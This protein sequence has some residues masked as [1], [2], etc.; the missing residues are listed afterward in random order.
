MKINLLRFIQITFLLSLMLIPDSGFAQQDKA[1]NKNVNLMGKNNSGLPASALIVYIDEDF[2]GAVGTTPPTGW[3]QNIIIGEQ[4]VDLW[5]FD[6]PGGVSINFPMT[7]PTAIFDSYHL[8]NNNLSENV[9]LESP[10]FSIEEGAGVMLEFDHYFASGLGGE[11]FIEVWNGSAWIT[12]YN[13]VTTTIGNPKHEIIDISA[14]ASSVTNSKVRFRWIGNFSYYWI[15]DN[16]KVYSADPVPDPATPI[17]P[18]DG[19][20]NV[21]INSGLSW[22]TITGA[23]PTGYRLYFGTDGAGIT[24][25][26]NIEDNMDMQLATD[27]MPEAPLLYNTTYYWMVIPYNETGDATGVPIWSFTV[28]EDPP[29]TVYPYSED[30]EGSFPPL[31]YIRYTGLLAEPITINPTNSG[32]EQGDWRNLSSPINKAAKLNISGTSVNHWLMTTLADL[33]NGT[34]Y[35]LEFDLTLNAA[36]TSNPPNSGGIDDRFAVLVSTD[37]GITWL[38]SNIL[39][40]W[41]NSGSQNVYDELSPLGEHV[42][43]DLSAY[44]GMIQLG[45]YGESSIS[46]ADNDL[47]IDNLEIIEVPPPA[48]IF[49]INPSDLDFG[50]VGVGRL[51][52]STGRSKQFGR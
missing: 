3:T 34:D 27:Y 31:Y 1:Q 5:H 30:F 44:S 17:S 46:N 33:G 12:E 51:P 13:S 36:G 52:D 9:A 23:A 8:S 19:A 7:S 50:N 26:T 16:V 37:S 48:P 10:G 32:W 22:E 43:I 40:E 24:R 39:K 41:N 20:V 25:P 2:S 47:M 28:M 49:T 6:N 18:A 14:E 35:Q 42:I 21:D 29:V 38:Y 45:F 11:I 15:I 4:G